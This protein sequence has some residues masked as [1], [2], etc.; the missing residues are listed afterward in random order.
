M[1]FL[2]NDT[3][4]SLYTTKNNFKYLF[5]IFLFFCIYNDVNIM[6]LIIVTLVFL[7]FNSNLYHKLKKNKLLGETIE[8]FVGD[9]D[10]VPYVKEEDNDNNNMDNKNII[11]ENFK[12][13]KELN[14]NN[15]IKDEN[16]TGEIDKNKNES[17]E[18]F[19]L[20]VQEIKEMY[21]NI[22]LQLDKMN[23]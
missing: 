3:K 19:K 21:D 5:I 20:S 15:D 14:K 8:K 13:I 7:Y 2:S 4:L 12:D 17:I 11:S 23:E 6:F 1:F 22:K 10:V 9:Y 18:P 16:I